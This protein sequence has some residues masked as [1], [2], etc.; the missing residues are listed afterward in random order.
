MTACAGCELGRK[1]EVKGKK[2]D[3]RYVGLT[4]HDLRR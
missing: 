4:L 1:I 2:Y 3:P